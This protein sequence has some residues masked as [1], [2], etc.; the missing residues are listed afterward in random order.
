MGRKRKLLFVTVHKQP[1]V[2]MSACKREATGW[3]EGWSVTRYKVLIK[4]LQPSP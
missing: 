2:A 3:D 1:A 4:S